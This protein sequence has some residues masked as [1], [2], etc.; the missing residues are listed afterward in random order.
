MRLVLLLLSFLAGLGV[1]QAFGHDFD[2]P[3]EPPRSPAVTESA[4]PTPMEAAVSV[5]ASQET[6]QTQTNATPTVMEVSVETPTPAPATPIPHDDAQWQRVDDAPPSSHVVETVLQPPRTPENVA[7]EPQLPDPAE[8]LSAETNYRESYHQTIQA[9]AARMDRSYAD[10][11]RELETQRCEQLERALGVIDGVIVTAN[12]ELPT[13]PEV[14]P[15]VT[16]VCVSV[17]R[18]Y[19][20]ELCRLNAPTNENV[21]NGYAAMRRVEEAERDRIRTVVQALLP[22]QQTEVLITDHRAPRTPGAKSRAGIAAAGALPGAMTRT[23]IFSQTSL[24]FIGLLVFLVA[25]FAIRGGV[26]PSG[27]YLPGWMARTRGGANFTL[28]T[29]QDDIGNDRSAA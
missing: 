1:C 17:P 25:F 12:I 3:P 27:G 9:A 10:H 21:V 2:E 29:S 24:I 11:K 13:W 5:D 16:A 22:N 26:N 15:E 14:R 8:V 4:D 28:P 7:V 20:E 18:R 19:F 23:P 6:E